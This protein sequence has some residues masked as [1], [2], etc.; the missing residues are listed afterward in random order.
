MILKDV[1]I[2]DSPL[3]EEWFSHD[4]AGL[5]FVGSYRDI[6]Q[7]LKLV[8]E[9]R[10]FWLAYENDIPVGFLDLEVDGTRGSSSIYVAPDQRQKGFSLKLHSALAEQARKLGATDLFGYVELDNE[11]SI[12]ALEKAGYTRSPGLDKDGLLEYSLKIR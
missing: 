2:A 8:G 7:T 11:A 10:K 1:T 6:E 12:R 9:H 4:E 3:F 5:K